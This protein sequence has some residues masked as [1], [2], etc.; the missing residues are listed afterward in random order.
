MKKGTTGTLLHVF[1]FSQVELLNDGS[2]TLNILVLEVIEQLSAL[3]YHSDQGTLSGKIFSVCLQVACEVCNALSK[4]CNLPFGRTSVG[5][6]TAVC[7]EDFS[8]RFCAY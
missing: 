6:G 4:E 5:L 8:L 2:V 7:F 3:T 1:L